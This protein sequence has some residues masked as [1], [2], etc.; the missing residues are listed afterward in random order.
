VPL[1]LGGAAIANAKK[2]GRLGAAR[3]EAS[4]A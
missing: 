2:R 4:A 1:I 3:P